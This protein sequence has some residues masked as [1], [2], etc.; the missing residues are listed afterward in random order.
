MRSSIALTSAKQMRALA[1]PLRMQILGELRVGGP[2]TVGALCDVFD[3]APG[4]LS[5]HLRQARRVRL[6]RGGAGIGRRSPGTL[7]ALRPRV[8]CRLPGRAGC[9]GGRAAG[10]RCRR[11][12]VADVYAATLHR[13]I[14]GEEELP[15]QWVH[16]ATFDDT[17]AFL[18]ADEL[19]DASAE[20]RAVAEKWHARGERGRP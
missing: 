12:Q 1:H 16:A 10:I 3:E 8:H 9:A 4:T 2:R 17:V 19:A 5:Y 11:H 7:V 20:L 13:V 14:D 18:T 15:R 6:R